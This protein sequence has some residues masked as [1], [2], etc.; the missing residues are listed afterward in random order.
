M[1]M[2]KLYLRKVKEEYMSIDDVPLYGREK[3][4]KELGE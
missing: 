3:V 4:R 2:V 1:Q